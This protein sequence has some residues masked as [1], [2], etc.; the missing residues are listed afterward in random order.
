MI[1]KKA[2]PEKALGALLI[3]EAEAGDF[4]MVRDYCAKGTDLETSTLEGETALMV[5]A[6]NGHLHIVEFL[7]GQGANVNA[8]N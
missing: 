1:E 7:I 3:M 8:K 5:A 4:E 2:D 6:R